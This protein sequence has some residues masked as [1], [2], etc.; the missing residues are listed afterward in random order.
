MPDV[1][2]LD[3]A[4]FRA[5]ID[6]FM[7]TLHFPPVDD[8]AWSVIDR[9]LE[10]GAMIGVQDAGELVATAAAVSFG[11][12]VPGGG[13]VPMAGVTFVGT[14][15][16]HTRRGLLTAMMNRQLRDFRDRG[17]PVAT[18]RP[19]EP[20]IYGRFGYGPATRAVTLTVNR[21][22]AAQRNP[23]T[24]RIVNRGRLPEL[25]RRFD[26]S[27]P[28]A[29]SRPDAWWDLL[30]LF[31]PSATAPDVAVVHLDAAGVEDGFAVYGIGADATAG[32]ALQVRDVWATDPRAYRELWQ[33]LLSV[34]M[35]RTIEA[36]MRPRDEP[37]DLLC[38][39]PSAA[40]I[41]GS[42]HETWLR[43]VDVPAALGARTYGAD[44]VVL[45]VRDDRIPENAG[46]YRVGADGVRRT[47]EEPELHCDVAALATLY[48][49]DRSP[50]ELVFAGLLDGADD[51]VRRAGVVFGTS[52]VPWCGTYF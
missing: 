18:L 28:G 49:G 16:D 3:V 50:A 20:T 10:P 22:A 32:S 42:T 47:D 19:T 30:P 7:G 27:R 4:E 46:T 41:T 13:T 9:Y 35:V 34:D 14:R 37:V 26:P 43:L 15:A 36:S 17:L 52:E 2:T 45:A 48:L 40:R 12:R 24:V 5:A 51:A 31:N 23:G 44:S 25:Y 21:R 6:L 1:R 33:Y 8:K 11:L 38:A 29:V 39:D